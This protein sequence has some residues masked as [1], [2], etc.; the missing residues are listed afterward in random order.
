M[1]LLELL[2]IRVLVYTRFSVD[3]Y[4]HTVE[5]N[6]HPIKFFYVIALYNRNSII[7]G[8]VATPGRIVPQSQTF[9]QLPRGGRYDYCIESQV[10][11]P[12]PDG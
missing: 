3:C 11:Q 1:V 8:F 4:R 5:N 9:L 6:P 10:I 7:V 12:P 2:V